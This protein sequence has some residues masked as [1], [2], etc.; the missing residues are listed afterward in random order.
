MDEELVRSLDDQE[1]LEVAS[2]GDF[3]PE[4]VPEETLSPLLEFFS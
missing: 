4:E 2:A 3:L 1:R